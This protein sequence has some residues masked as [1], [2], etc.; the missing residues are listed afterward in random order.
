MPTTIPKFYFKSDDSD[1]LTMALVAS[2]KKLANEARIERVEPL[3]LTADD[4]DSISE[5]MNRNSN[6]SVKDG[7][8]MSYD[9]FQTSKNELPRRLAWIFKPSLFMRSYKYENGKI[10]TRN[11]YSFITRAAALIEALFT[12]TNYSREFDGFLVSILSNYRRKKKCSSIL[13]I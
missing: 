3:L 7:N 4:L 13:K 12:L 5:T 10:S 8:L 1:P 6:E 9:Q 2:F 11:F